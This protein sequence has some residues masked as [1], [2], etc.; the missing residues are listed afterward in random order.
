MTHD[1]PSVAGFYEGWRLTNDRLIEALAPL[2]G[3][4]LAWRPGPEMWPI[5]ALAGHLAGARVYWL[6]SI[7]N[8]PG[9]AST[10]FTDP[11]GDGWEDHPSEP[12]GADDLVFA[13]RTSWAIVAD[14]L[15]RWSPEMLR[16][17][18]ERVRGDV[19]QVHTR[20]SVLIRLITHDAY[21]CGEISQLL[22]QHGRPDIEIW[23]GLSRVRSA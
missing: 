15:R 10:P 5:W 8:E 14:C 19:V 18:F 3:E 16:V 13:L 23:S 7:L 12:R 22:G 1:G 2:S 9:A 20:Q 4:E 6:C 11:S 21:H 17:E